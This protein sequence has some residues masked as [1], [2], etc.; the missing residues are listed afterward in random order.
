MATTGIQLEK[1]SLQDALDLATLIEE[2]ARDRYE[3]LADQML[4]HRAPA[5]EAFFRKMVRVEEAHRRELAQRRA[6]L[7]GSATPA[8]TRAQLFDVEA[9]DYDEVRYGMSARAALE[10]ALRCEIKAHEFFAA[11]L[12]QIRDAAV[13][14]LFAELRDE[15]IVHQNWVRAEIERLPAADEPEGDASDEPVAL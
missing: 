12:P 6:Q 2:E 4:V 15:E 14:A 7:F 1:L 10:V 9:P 3:E 11:A 8:V 13:Q 5:V